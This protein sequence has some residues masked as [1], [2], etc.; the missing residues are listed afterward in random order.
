[1]DVGLFCDT[2]EIFDMSYKPVGGGGG[3]RVPALNMN[4]KGEYK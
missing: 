2:E 4:Y 3:V 1:M